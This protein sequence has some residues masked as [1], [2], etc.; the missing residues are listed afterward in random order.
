[1]V[2]ATISGTV[3]DPTGGV[4][5]GVMIVIKNSSTGSVATADTN[6]A[7]VY[8]AANLA[9]GTYDVTASAAGFSTLVRNR[10]TL[11][12]GQELVLNLT[13]QVG[14]TSQQIEVSTEA[15][16]VDL[17]NATVGGVVSGTNV[18]ELPL[19]GRSWSDLA[20][21]AP[22]V[23]TVGN[24]PNIS[25]TDRTKRGMGLELS[26]AGGRPQQNNYLMDGVNI[27]NY[28]NAG[29]GSL[30]GGNLGTDA[31]GE[32]SVLTTNYTAEYGRTSGGVIS[33]ITRSGANQFHGTAYEFL[34]NKSLD[35]ANYID[36]ISGIPKPP[37]RRNQ[38]GGSIGGPI[39]K[40]KTFFFTD[41]EGVRQFLGSTL[42]ATVPT[43]ADVAA[44]TA[45]LAAMT[46]SVTPDPNALLYLKTFWP[47]SPTGIF[48]FAGNQITGENF[49]IGRVDHT[50]SEKNRIF[51]TYLYDNSHQTEPDEM[52]N[53]LI[54]NQS[55]RETIAVEWSHIFNPQ[56][57]NSFRIGFNRDNTAS[58]D[59]AT[60]TN[61]AAGNLKFGFDP[62][63]SVGSLEVDPYT[64]FS[65][66]TV[67]SSPFEFIW[68]SF[69]F[70]DNVYYTTGIHSIKIGANAEHIQQ[71]FFGLD[72][73]GGGWVFDNLV[74]FFLNR[75]SS[76]G[77]D[78]LGT[79]TP[80]Y[81]PM[82]IAA[83][84]IQDDIHFRPNLT[85]NV[86]LRYEFGSV[87]YEIDGKLANLRM[88]VSTPNTPPAPFLGSPYFRNP[89]KNDWEPRIG[90][91]WDP[92]KNGKSSIRGIRNV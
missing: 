24:Q 77:S 45:T 2:G 10:I 73:P 18:E 15:P 5:P 33:A 78:A 62:G 39:H 23:H 12:V 11:T 65:G 21:L 25:S 59:G 63:Y 87:P 46:P 91:A 84:Y 32:F 85:F 54:H 71:K 76:F 35:A 44:A 80:R 20:I 14:S 72:S 7:G 19:N 86:G 56:L 22:G 30:L 28:T 3:V 41:Y 27:N 17:A 75:A 92:F 43:A 31:V 61:P 66:G 36:D 6:G 81:E 88:L 68:N 58:P 89:T 1:M 26:I 8:D 60:A 64:I 49:V 79:E 40:D 57:L 9:P 51:G 38:F 13:L 4:V 16:T 37:F 70:Y 52:N 90:F 69:Q 47:A 48:T 53:K 42:T 55:K 50:F 74:D 67:V 34:R 83:G 82:S 29:P